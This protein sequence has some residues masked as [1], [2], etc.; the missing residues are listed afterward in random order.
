M[1]I[2][3]S[4]SDDSKKV[5]LYESNI[6]E[7][8]NNEHIYITWSVGDS[9][10]NEYKQYN[11]ILITF[12]NNNGRTGTA[13]FK[14]CML[15]FGSTKTGYSPSPYD[16]INSNFKFYDVNSTN[17]SFYTGSMARYNATAQNG[18]CIES[19]GNIGVC[20]LNNNQYEYTQ[21]AGGII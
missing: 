10:L 8:K 21:I 3:L 6:Y 20:K 19:E 1:R 13:S 2:Y 15:Y 9:T 5:K 12:S 11:K 16:A 14:H 4:N 7:G 18:V 17:T